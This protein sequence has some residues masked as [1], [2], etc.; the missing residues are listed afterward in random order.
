MATLEIA[1]ALANEARRQELKTKAALLKGS[2][3]ATASLSQRLSTL[4]NDALREYER[5]LGELAALD[6]GAGPGVTADF[7]PKS[8]VT[9]F[10][11][12]ERAA[13]K[14]ACI[15]FVKAHPA[16]TEDEAAEAWDTGAVTSHAEAL[17]LPAQG[18]L[19]MGR[20]YRRNLLAAQL[21][22]N[23]TWEDQRAWIVA[24]P[25]AAILA[26]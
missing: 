4:N 20:L 17:D 3:D 23:A 14:E 18:G 19:A 6:A 12:V 16:C 5:V 25:K 2:M 8:T 10:L 26:A 22:A 9:Q 24:T 1:T 15:D 11:E 13:A 7:G 21:I